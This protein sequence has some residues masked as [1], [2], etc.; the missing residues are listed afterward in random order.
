MKTKMTR[1]TCYPNGRDDKR[2]RG[3]LSKLLYE[4]AFREKLFSSSNISP[5]VSS[6][7]EEKAESQQLN[8]IG[9]KEAEA[10][11]SSKQDASGKLR[12]TVSASNFLL[13]C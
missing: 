8:N 5:P 7:D 10:A 12:K 3:F 1:K 9:E 6:Q 13:E 2:Y 4:I 11:S